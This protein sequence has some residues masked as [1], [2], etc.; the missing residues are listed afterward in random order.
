MEEYEKVVIKCPSC[1]K[2]MK[3]VKLKKL[4]TEGLLCQKCGGEV[5]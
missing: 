2:K 4:S 1:G 5:D 3:L